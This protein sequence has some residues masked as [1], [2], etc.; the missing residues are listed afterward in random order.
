[1]IRIEHMSFSY[2]PSES[3]FADLS[4]TLAPGT[5]Y[6]LLGLNGAGK[7]TL[8]KLITGLLFPTTGSLRSL[9]YDPAAR[10]PGLLSQIFMLP[11]ELNMPRL[12]AE[13]YLSVR[14]PFYPRFDR[15]AFER[16]AAEFELPH[17]SKLTEYSYGQKKKFL[18]SFGLACGSPLLVMD[19]PT[20][21]LDIPSKGLFRRLV[22]EAVADDRLF[23][24]S[25]HQVR[26]VE[27]LIDPIVI[28]HEGKVLFNYS[29]D[30]ISTHLRMTHTPSK[31]SN[32]A[33][34]L[35]HT[36]PAV[37]G[38]WSVWSDGTASEGP[39][40]LEVLFNTVISRPELGA[41]LVA[42]RHKTAQGASV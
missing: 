31:P 1:M 32:D 33:D 24:I 18:L 19:E 6:G 25:T 28:I 27:S 7:T 2:R 21:G 11:E 16:Y 37:G 42:S 14:A 36:E 34:G 22:A 41:A 26:D 23:I 5:V 39:L 10:A 9:G 40:D 8:L 13:E 30:E 12:T 17:A 35:L 29:I 38:F 20:N 4:L 3:L 15:A